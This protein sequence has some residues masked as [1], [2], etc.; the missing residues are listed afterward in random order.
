MSA[1]EDF[2]LDAAVQPLLDWYQLNKRNLPWRLDT[3]P[4]HIWVSE[5]MLQQT[6]VEAVKP[7]YERFLEKLPDVHALS[8]CPQEKLLKLWEGLGY[9]NRVR[10]MQKAAKILESEYHGLFPADYEA[11]RALPGIGSYTAGAIASIAFSIPVPAVDGNVLRILMRLTN[12]DSDIA[13]QSVKTRAEA[14]LMPV[15]PPEKPGEFNQALMELGAEVCLP[16]GSPRCP[17]CPWRSFCLAR[18]NGRETLLPIRKKAR[19]RRI[20]ERT[21]LLICGGS[22]VVINRRKMT[23]LLAGLYEFP[24]VSGYLSEEETLEHVKSLGLTPLHIRRLPDA[25]HIFSHVE[26]H[27][28]GYQIRVDDLT[29]EDSGLLFVEMEEARKTYA[30]P[31]AFAVYKKVLTGDIK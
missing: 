14:A 23:G 27:M 8:E 20:E 13:K 26:W 15:M 9:Y 22:S 2:R 30:I 10:N 21:I 7:Y 29:K 25:V 17:D 4:Y 1:L 5:I 6:R 12:D 18:Q 28:R 19:P 11:I 24:G 16:N 3:D 31:A